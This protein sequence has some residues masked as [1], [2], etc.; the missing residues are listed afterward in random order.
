MF[1][2]GDI[3]TEISKA[4]FIFALLSFV[5]MNGIGITIFI[6]FWGN[7]LAVF[8]FIL[9]F[10]VGICSLGVLIGLVSDYAYIKDDRLYMSYIF[11]KSSI[12]LKDIGGVKLKNDIY[13]VYDKKQG[14][15]GTINALA[16]GIDSITNELDRKHVPFI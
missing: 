7:M 8:A 3:S 15:V 1:K 10:I 5:L 14:E 13:H 16:Q 12:D 9:M 6:V 2:H 11:K 4:Q